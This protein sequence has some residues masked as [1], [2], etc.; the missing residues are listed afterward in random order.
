MGGVG[1][2]ESRC[3]VETGKG[4]WRDLPWTVTGQR[5]RTDRGPRTPGRRRDVKTKNFWTGR[6]PGPGRVDSRLMED[7]TSRACST[8]VPP[9]HYTV[10]QCGWGRTGFSSTPPVVGIP[11][12]PTHSRPDWGRQSPV[13]PRFSLDPY[14]WVPPDT[15]P[16]P[17]RKVA[18]GTRV[19]SGTTSTPRDRDRL[20]LRKSETVRSDS[21]EGMVPGPFR[22]R[23]T[24][25]R[26]PSL[27]PGTSTT[28]V[29]FRRGWSLG[30]T[31]A[32][33]VV[34]TPVPEVT[35]PPA[36]EI[37]NRRCPRFSSSPGGSHSLPRSETVFWRRRV[38]E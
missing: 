14:G 21:W 8:T 28:P 5:S 35:G 29:R 9:F 6:R 27:S 18:P 2:V 30:S 24:R 7:R 17:R 11:T 31:R 22:R 33:R 16:P 34:R 15:P 37:E 25:G 38:R 23:R 13:P 3:L 12:C 10:G 26:R 32:N 1:W 19:W 4:E 20:R 36:P